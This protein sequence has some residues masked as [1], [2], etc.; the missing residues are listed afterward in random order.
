[1]RESRTYGSVRGAR[2]NSSPYRERRCRLIPR[3]D[4]ALAAVNICGIEQI[5]GAPPHQKFRPP[6][7]DRIAAPAPRRG[8]ARIVLQPRKREDLAPDLPG[9]RDLLAVG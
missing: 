7:S 1:M 5:A 2:G 6:G 8:L 3:D 9:A 4:L